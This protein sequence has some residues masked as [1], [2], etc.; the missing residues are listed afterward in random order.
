MINGYSEIFESNT[1]YETILKN[2]TLEEL[3]QMSKFFGLTIPQ[4]LI[5]DEF[6]KQMAEKVLSDAP[7][8]LERLPMYEMDILEKLLEKEPG[9][10]VAM[11]KTLFSLCIFELNLVVVDE[12]TLPDAFIYILCDDVRNAILPHIYEIHARLLEHIEDHVEKIILG[13]VNIYGRLGL[14]DLKNRVN[15]LLT[16]EKRAKINIPA[17]FEKSFLVDR[18][19][20]HTRG[21]EEFPD[22]EFYMITP[23]Y[24]DP[25][26]FVKNERRGLIRNV[27]F[28]YILK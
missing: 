17:Y 13:L 21:F 28:I 26:W 27:Q 10:Y 8:W 20:I 25:Q 22:E 15:F 11:P 5:K 19:L 9:V 18:Y 24:P 7:A 16:D 23:V 14:S 6:V 2:N 4:H 3:K 12:E 1:S